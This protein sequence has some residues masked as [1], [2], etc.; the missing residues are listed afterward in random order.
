MTLRSERLKVVLALE[1]RKEQAA[2]DRLNEVRRHWQ[3]EQD[4]VQEL[5]RYQSEYHQ[6]MRAQQQ[7]TV[8]VARLQGW[9]SFISRLDLLIGD[10]QQRLEQAGQRLEQA[11]QQ[12][13]QAWERRRGM[14]K[15]IETCR[16]VE[17]RARDLSEQKQ[18]DEAAA[19]QF[20]RRR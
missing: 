15:Y 8:P 9:Q 14:E 7:G 19:R 5:Q 4:R 10:Q 20:A 18:A 2:V 13:Q 17:Q 6:Q 16:G 11:R 12:W 1:E 3:A